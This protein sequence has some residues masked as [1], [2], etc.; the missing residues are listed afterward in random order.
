MLV[1]KFVTR[2]N[3]REQPNL[4]G[5]ILRV[6]G[7]GE[8]GVTWDAPILADGHTWHFLQLKNGLTGYAAVADGPT[9]LYTLEA[10]PNTFYSAVSFTLK[11]EGGYSNNPA[12]PGGE[13]NFGISKRSYPMLDIKNLTIE[14]AKAI[15]YLDYWLPV[16]AANYPYP[17]DQILFDIGVLTGVSRARSYQSYSALQILVSQYRYFVG[18]TS[19]PTF[20]AGWIRRNTDLLSLL[21]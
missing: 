14:Q 18:L 5:K 11:W 1:A 17:K 21:L 19:F 6:M 15:Y 2:T 9:P 13:T 20:G 3:I 10:L 4:K 8:L 12:D 16:E 7:V